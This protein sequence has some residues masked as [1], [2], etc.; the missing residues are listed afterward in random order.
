MH[1]LELTFFQFDFLDQSHRAIRW[2]AARSEAAAIVER[3]MSARTGE[4]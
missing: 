4:A 3:D 1:Q 2:F